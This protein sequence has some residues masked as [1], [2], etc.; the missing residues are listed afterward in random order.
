MAGGAV[1]EL[2]KADSLIEW[3]NARPALSREA[4]EA[5]AKSFQRSLTVDWIGLYKAD[6]SLREAIEQGRTDLVPETVQWAAKQG[7]P[8]TRGEMVNRHPDMPPL[9]DDNYG[10]GKEQDLGFQCDY[11]RASFER[12]WIGGEP[13]PPGFVKRV[14]VLLRKAR[15]HNRELRFLRAWHRHMGDELTGASRGSLIER[16]QKLENRRR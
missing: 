14:A 9:P 8:V 16:L 5:L 2:K 12:Y 1:N 15:E 6:L 13:V 4:V 10:R 11:V 3:L 7:V